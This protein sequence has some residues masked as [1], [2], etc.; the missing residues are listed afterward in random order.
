[1]RA[2][3]HSASI[4]LQA[5]GKI[6]MKECLLLR[7]DCDYTFYGKVQAVIPECGGVIDGS[8]F[9]DKVTLRAHIAPEDLGGLQARLADATGGTCQI[10]EEGKDYFEFE[11]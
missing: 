6:L 9:T 3:S 5:A 1:M 8:E 11:K 10:T 7:L 2:Y 4:A